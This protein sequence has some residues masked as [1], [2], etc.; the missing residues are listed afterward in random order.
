MSLLKR[1]GK[2]GGATPVPEICLKEN[3][4]S[5]VQTYSLGNRLA[6]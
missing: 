4:A 3:L 1:N 6:S 2:S 5:Q